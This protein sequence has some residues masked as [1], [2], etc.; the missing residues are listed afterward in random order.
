MKEESLRQA[1]LSK[2]TLDKAL[3]QSAAKTVQYN[4]ERTKQ[5]TREL[6][7]QKDL[8]DAKLTCMTVKTVLE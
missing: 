8:H 6:R 3:E 1:E 5:H 4:S 7:L 2:Q